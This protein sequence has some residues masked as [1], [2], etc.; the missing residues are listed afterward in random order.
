MKTEE[1][2]KI[3]V[4]KNSKMDARD[5]RILCS[6]MGAASM[7]QSVVIVAKC[8]QFLLASGA[9]LLILGRFFW[10]SSLRRRGTVIA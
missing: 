6:V 4:P 9:I 7:P 10:L 3:G 1:C 2:N 8:T 5:G